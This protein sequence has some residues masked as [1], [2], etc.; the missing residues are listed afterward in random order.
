[1][2]GTFLTQSGDSVL[3]TVRVIPRATRSQIAGTRNDALL[4]RLSSPPVDGAANAEL[5][6][7]L[8]D[9]LGVPR[10][11]VTLVSG[12]RSRSKRV[13]VAGMAADDVRRALNL[14]G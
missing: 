3:I 13:R 1:V 12:E 8:S 6:D 5:I 2:S 10:R 4:V 7:V 9:A 11:S 14:S